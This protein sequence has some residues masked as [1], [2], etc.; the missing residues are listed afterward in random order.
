MSE[1]ETQ[2]LQEQIE[3]EM[4]E[5]DRQLESQIVSSLV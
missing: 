4:M 5:Y 2:N 3:S 1:S